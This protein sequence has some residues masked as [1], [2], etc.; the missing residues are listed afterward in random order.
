MHA[1]SPTG[2]QLR[3]A[4]AVTPLAAQVRLLRECVAAARRGGLEL[5]TFCVHWRDGRPDWTNGSVQSDVRARQFDVF[6]NA[7]QLPHTL[8]ETI[9]HE[10]QHVHDHAAGDVVDRVTLEERAIAFAARMTSG[11]LY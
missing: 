4:R 11:R 7:N 1:A 9:F 3:A 10:L 5:P 6:L 8:R 2:E